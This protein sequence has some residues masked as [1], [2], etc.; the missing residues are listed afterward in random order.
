MLSNAK[1]ILFQKTRGTIPWPLTCSS[2]RRLPMSLLF[3]SNGIATATRN[4][5]TR[6]KTNN[7]LF[8]AFYV[9]VAF[10]L[11]STILL[12]HAF[13]MQ[14]MLSQETEILNIFAGDNRPDPLICSSPELISPTALKRIAISTKLRSRMM[15]F[16]M[17]FM[18]V[19]LQN[20]QLKMLSKCKNNSIQKTRG[21]A[22]N[23]GSQR[24]RN[25]HVTYTQDTKRIMNFPMHFMLVK[26]SDYTAQYY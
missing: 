4:I 19:K 1:Q 13:K 18:L 15:N 5:Y 14:E 21:L 20:T 2:L 26:P 16:S 11:H 17:H 3:S 10:R 6:Y 12:K 7:E 9:G 22:P 25:P 8:Y 23:A 24:D